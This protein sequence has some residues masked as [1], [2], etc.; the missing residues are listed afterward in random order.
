[1]GDNSGIIHL[2]K[3]VKNSENFRC[4]TSILDLEQQ[5]DWGHAWLR[6]V[7]SSRATGVVLGCEKVKK[8]NFTKRD[9]TIN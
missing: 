3:G 1:M 2:E 9:K 8:I 5:R 6:T 7:N 4:I